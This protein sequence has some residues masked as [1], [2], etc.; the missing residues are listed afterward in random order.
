M[1]RQARLHVEGGVYHVILRG[2]GGQNIF[3]AKQDRRFFFGVIAEGCRRFGYRVHGFCLM[4][5]HVHPID[6]VKAEH[7]MERNYFKGRDGER[8]NAVLAAAGYNF[9]LRIRWFEA[10][11]RP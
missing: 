5:N 3:F 10:L 4:S 9:S 11:L 2:N 7:R 8:A 1:A 6:H